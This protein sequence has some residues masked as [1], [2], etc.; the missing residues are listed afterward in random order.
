MDTSNAGVMSLNHEVMDDAPHNSKSMYTRSS[1]H[2]RRVLDQRIVDAYTLPKHLKS[3]GLRAVAFPSGMT[4]INGILMATLERACQNISATTPDSALPWVILGN[5]LY[6]DVAHTIR[7]LRRLFRF[8]YEEV[9]ISCEKAVMRVVQKAGPNLAI[10]YIESCTNPSGQ[11]MD[12]Q[13]LRKIKRVSQRC[14]V[15]VDNTWLSS[16][17][18][19]PFVCP[20]VDVVVESMTKYIGGGRCIGGM[21][22]GASWILTKARKWVKTLGLFMPRVVCTTFVQGWDTLSARIQQSS[23]LTL[24]IATELEALTQQP[25]GRVLRV[26]H[27]LLASHP[28]HAAARKL[29][30]SGLGPSV[31][32]FCV[33][34]R[35]K[36]DP[37]IGMDRG[38]LSTLRS[39]AVICAILAASGLKLE[40]SY[41]SPYSKLEIVTYGWDGQ[42]ELDGSYDPISGLWLRLAVGYQD[43]FEYLSTSLKRMLAH[44]DTVP[45]N[46][47]AEEDPPMFLEGPTRKVTQ[48][49]IVDRCVS[50]ETPVTEEGAEISFG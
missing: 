22:V 31:L 4:A 25:G 50:P 46:F 27:P 11:M 7:Y 16:A 6:C 45:S 42:Y 44:I 47:A 19:N 12:F 9:D 38:G 10:V 20:A 8:I 32:L 1:S 37:G 34:L 39:C 36:I 41:G 14:I 2:A 30:T 35:C 5:E 28:T 13:I 17:V 3:G 40:T 24:Q 48:P 21:A 18:F 49:Y 23:T 29:L 15:C 26:L 33:D 43:T